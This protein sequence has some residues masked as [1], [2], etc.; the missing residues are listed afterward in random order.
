MTRI[1]NTEK[2]PSTSL[3]AKNKGG[4]PKKLIP[5]Q[6]TLNLLEGMSGIMA[7]E[8]EAAAMLGVH[9]STF[10]KFLANYSAAR[11]AW[12]NGREKGKMSL[13][14]SQ[15]KLAEKSAAMSIHLGM[16]YLDQQDRRG[17]NQTTINLAN[18]EAG[19]DGEEVRKFTLTIFDGGLIDRDDV[20]VI[21][22]EEPMAELPPPKT[23]EMP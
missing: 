8:K 7:T 10:E 15:F 17:L 5:T 22:H 9:P 1:V 18:I 6:Q 19:Q 21:E 11:E 23:S 14:R 16:N 12:N 20:K 3:T 13:R 4:R 2:R